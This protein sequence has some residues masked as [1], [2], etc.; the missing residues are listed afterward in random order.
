MN[1][2]YD[3]IL[4]ACEKTLLSFDETEE[5]LEYPEVQADKGYYLSLLEKYNSLS[6]IKGKYAELKDAISEEETVKQL[7]SEADEKEKSELYREISS[8]RRRISALTDELA[9]ALGYGNVTERV[10]CRINCSKTVSSKFGTQL[11]DLIKSDL[12]AKNVKLS[13]T[14][15]K[16]KNG[17]T[18]ITFFASGINALRRLTVLS[19]AHKVYIPLS[20]GEEITLA[21]TPSAEFCEEPKE[22]DLKID[23]FHS[24]GA[25]GQNINKVETAVRVT[26]IPTGTVVVCQDERS[27]IKNKKR[28]IETLHKRLTERKNA[29]EKERM[30]SDL[31][32][33]ERKVSAITFDSSTST[34]TDNR[35]TEKKFSFPPSAE[36]FGKYLDALMAIRN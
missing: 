11:F 12:S 10:F 15:T 33:Q 20:R 27:Q 5:L 7:L 24:S 1:A 34:M 29:E 35:L 32:I 25:G 2:L 17:A 28:A 30:E 26:H 8:I 3:D 19:G 21:V 31:R 9:S 13:D 6:A 4:K 14:V 36:Q 16:S 23:V 22:T 18:E